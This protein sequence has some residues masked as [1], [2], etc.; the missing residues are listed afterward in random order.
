MS[1]W[2][3]KVFWIIL[4]GLFFSLYSDPVAAL[5]QSKEPEY[6]IGKGDILE[7]NVWK[8]ED[9]TRTLIVRKDGRISLPLVNDIQAA[10]ITPMQLKKEIQAKLSEYIENPVVTVI[11]KS[12]DSKRYYIIGEIKNT[13]QY[14]L[15]KDLTI[16]QALALAG[17]FT[18]WADK[19]DILLLRKTDN[20][21]DQI[22][23]D[24]HKIISGDDYQQN[25]ILQPDDT[26]IVK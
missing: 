7:I 1:D 21:T 25:V 18:E 24:Y 11:V 22:K 3:R 9:L 12:Q 17:G 15:K 6:I 16:V 20:R 23:I 2:P 4:L 26:I 10:G 5:E 14:E 8:E 19:D 13:G